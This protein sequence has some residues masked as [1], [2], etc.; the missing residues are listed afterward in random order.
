MKENQLRK[1]MA[2]G[3][4]ILGMISFSGSPAIVEIIGYAG[5]DFVTIDTEHAPTGVESLG[6]LI[7]AAQC[8]GTTPLVRVPENSPTEIRRALEAGAMGVL[9]P[10]ANTAEY[11]RKAV[12]YVKY[13][14]DGIRGM[15]PSVRAAQFTISA[16][17][18]NE[19]YR[20]SNR[21]SLVIPI[22]EEKEGVDNLEE[23]MSVKG[24]DI[25]WLGI[26][27][28]SQSLGIPLQLD[29]P[30]IWEAIEKAV[31]VGRRH[32]VKI[33]SNAGGVSKA[34]IS[35]TERV[36][37]LLEK[38]VQLISIPADVRCFNWLCNDLIGR[39]K[40]LSSKVV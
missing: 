14:P 26:G 18:W 17:Y 24:V 8:A 6:N 15:C 31:E 30:K 13:P 40:N 29:H 33:M 23:I 27:D 16:E 32:G 36:K 3:K 35:S 39:M 22:V 7:R 21:D 2:E 10:H 34:G 1:M 38:G 11:V 28:L 5:F 37:K 12:S 20:G 25:V 19:Y 9:I 4:P